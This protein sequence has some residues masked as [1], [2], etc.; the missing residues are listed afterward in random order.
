MFSA[1]TGLVSRSSRMN[2]VSSAWPRSLVAMM[3]STRIVSPRS[4]RLPFRLV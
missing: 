1:S 2:P 4:D 3:L